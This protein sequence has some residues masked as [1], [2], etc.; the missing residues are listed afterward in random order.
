[1]KRRPLQRISFF[2]VNCQWRAGAFFYLRQPADVV[3]MAVGEDNYL[4]FQPHGFDVL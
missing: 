4:D 3:D 1:M 2:F